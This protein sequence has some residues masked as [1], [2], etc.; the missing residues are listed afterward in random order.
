MSSDNHAGRPRLV[1]LV[2]DRV[3]AHAPTT[4]VAYR[5]ITDPKAVDAVLRAKLI[6]EAAEAAQYPSLEEL[7][8][9]VEVVRALAER[10]GWDLFTDV[11]AVAAEKRCDWGG[12]TFGV[13]MYVTTTAERHG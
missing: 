12:F 4:E 8:D 3:G 11:L 9:V 10:G 13:G 7:A 1:K 5:P 2:R 6:E